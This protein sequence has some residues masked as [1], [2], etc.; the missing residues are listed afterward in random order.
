MMEYLIELVM[1]GLIGAPIGMFLMLL[2]Q[3]RLW[4]FWCEEKCG[5]KTEA[6]D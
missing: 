4:K 3:R 1:G 2:C 5:C 6:P